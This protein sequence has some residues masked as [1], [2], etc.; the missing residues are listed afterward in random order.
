MSRNEGAGDNEQSPSPVGSTIILAALA[1]LAFA[2]NSL[3]NRAALAGGVIDAGGFTAIRLGSGAIFLSA[4]ML[5]RNGAKSLRFGRDFRGAV[6]LCLY[7]ACFSFAYLDLPA[8]V[9]ALI[10]FASVQI[11]MQAIALYR[12]EKINHWQAG[13]MAVAVGGLIY[14]LA[15]GVEPP[16]LFSAVLM[17]LSGFAWGV[18]SILG[19]DGQDPTAATTRNFLVAA[20]LSCPLLLLDGDV[21]L[22]KEGVLLAIFGG[23]V[24]SALGYIVWYTLLPRLKATIAAMLQLLVPAIAAYGGILF[25]GE[26]L[27]ARLTIATMMIIAGI[28]VHIWKRERS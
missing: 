8:G 12:G 11:S 1:L 7:A 18:Y 26:I 24:T 6:A 21:A 2:G 28:F 22:Q 9:G 5:V 17:M 10:L 20:L 13:G 19:K 16:P 14:L 4:L 23:V 15:P 3:I 25:L 27:T